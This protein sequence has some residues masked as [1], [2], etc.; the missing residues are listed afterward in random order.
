M[1]VITNTSRRVI[2]IHDEM[3]G[4]FVEVTLDCSH[5]LLVRRGNGIQ[6]GSRRSCQDCVLLIKTKTILEDYQTRLATLP[7]GTLSDTQITLLSDIQSRYA[8]DLQALAEK[9]GIG[10][11]FGAHTCAAIADLEDTA[12]LIAA[13]VEAVKHLRMYSR[14]CQHSI[15][16]LTQ[17][18]T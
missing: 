7:W 4:Y 15:E 13:D 14:N 8:R 1:T 17:K 6:I 10:L 9:S 18:T 16:R 5:R 11:L 12:L 2:E 3:R